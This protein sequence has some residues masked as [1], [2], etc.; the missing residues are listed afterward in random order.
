MY[1]F[2]LQVFVSLGSDDEDDGDEP[3]IVDDE[4]ETIQKE[5]VES[6]KEN[7]IPKEEPK[8]PPNSLEKY[9]SSDIENSSSTGN[10]TE[11]VQCYVKCLCKVIVSGWQ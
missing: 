7:I 5:S 10:F 1:C 3:L 2:L 11:I 9:S 4:E 8:G 6:E